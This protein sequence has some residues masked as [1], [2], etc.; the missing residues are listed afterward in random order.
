MLHK[1]FLTTS[2]APAKDLPPEGLPGY[3]H[4]F[5]SIFECSA[6]GMLVLNAT[7]RCVSVNQA[8]CNLIGYTAEEVLANSLPEFT[9]PDDLPARLQMLRQLISGEAKSCQ[10]EKR[11]IHKS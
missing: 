7:G 10:L 4:L 2:M 6:A 1:S 8:F 11:Y 3:A 5:E 9:H